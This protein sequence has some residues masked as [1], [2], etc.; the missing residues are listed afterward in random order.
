MTDTAVEKRP[1]DGAALDPEP[2]APN[3]EPVWEREQPDGGPLGA[4][5]TPLYL[6]FWS[7]MT[8]SLT[9]ITGT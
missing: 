7:A 3:G 6:R 2:P 4:L 8:L 5:K 9:G 1:A